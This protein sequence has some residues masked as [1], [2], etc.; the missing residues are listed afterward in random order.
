MF[1]IICI[2]FY[3]VIDNG[4][5]NKT[6]D[7]FIC[8]NFLTLKNIF[9]VNTSYSSIN[10]ITKV[11]DLPCITVDLLLV[12]NFLAQLVDHH[13]WQKLTQDFLLFQYATLNIAWISILLL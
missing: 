13:Y 2:F 10:T 5:I 8:K 9:I 7:S 1:F 12:G 11:F 4:L 6:M 3:D